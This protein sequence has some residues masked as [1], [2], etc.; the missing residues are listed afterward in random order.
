MSV[1]WIIHF[2]PE[3]SLHHLWSKTRVYPYTYSLERRQGRK[4]RNQPKSKVILRCL[5]IT[6]CRICANQ[7]FLCSAWCSTEWYKNMVALIATIH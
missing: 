4:L 7:A 2:R 5:L 1:S 3:I 6:Q